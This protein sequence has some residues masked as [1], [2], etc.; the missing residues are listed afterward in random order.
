MG[1]LKNSLQNLFLIGLCVFTI[2]A[3][4]QGFS[5]NQTK[6]L[7]YFSSILNSFNQGYV[8]DSDGD[9]ELEYMDRTFW[10]LTDTPSSVLHMYTTVELSSPCSFE[11]YKLLN[12]FNREGTFSKIWVDNECSLLY[13]E[14]FE[15]MQNEEDATYTIE[16]GIKELFESVQFYSELAKKQVI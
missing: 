2:E 10:I 15:A 16:A 11:F 13:I 6:N 8:I 9:I 14:L 7:Q 4:S 12:T 5:D 3:H 1:C